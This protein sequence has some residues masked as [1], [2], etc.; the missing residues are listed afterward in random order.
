MI[1]RGH[2][3]CPL[4]GGVGCPVCSALR[5][6][7]ESAQQERRD[8]E[9]IAFLLKAFPDPEHPG[10]F[11]TPR[12]LYDFLTVVVAA[13]QYGKDCYSQQTRTQQSVP[14]EEETATRFALIDF[15]VAPLAPVN[16]REHREQTTL[17]FEAVEFD[18]VKSKR[19]SP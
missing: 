4:C 17:R 15:E 2:P 16:D 8:E 18:E 19:K 12:G 5:E 9:A 1:H 11:R 13:I 14:P 6:Y 3:N 10:Q 7:E